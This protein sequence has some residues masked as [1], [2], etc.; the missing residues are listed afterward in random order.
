MFFRRMTASK[1]QAS[2][3]VS[4][5]EMGALSG[6]YD[7]VVLKNVWISGSQ[8]H[9]RNGFAMSGGIM[10]MSIQGGKDE[11]VAQCRKGLDCCRILMRL[12]SAIVVSAGRSEEKPGPRIYI[13][14]RA[15]RFVEQ[16]WQESFAG[17][18]FRSPEEFHSPLCL[19]ST[20]SW[21]SLC[22]IL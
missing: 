6:S 4:N 20:C 16:E 9:G 7:G 5:G 15:H 22:C 12:S 8:G 2:V 18:F 1:L 13:L 19:D 21:H 3:E 14:I 10:V 11:L 17:T